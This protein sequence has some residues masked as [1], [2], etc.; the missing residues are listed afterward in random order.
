[1]KICG[2]PAFGLRFHLSHCG[3]SCGCHCDSQTRARPTTRASSP[4]RIK[5]AQAIIMEGLGHF[6][7]SEDPAR[8]LGH[9]RPVLARIATGD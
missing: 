9:L 8:F 1:M 3:S 4:R 5:R 7:V 2:N 6:P